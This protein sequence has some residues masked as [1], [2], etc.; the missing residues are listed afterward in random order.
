MR[1]ADAGS[2]APV[3]NDQKAPGI[4]DR[5]QVEPDRLRLPAASGV[6]ALVRARLIDRVMEEFLASGGRRA[7]ISIGSGLDTRL[8]RLR[9][10]PD[11][12]ID[13]DLPEVVAI[14]REV[15]PD[16]GASCTLAGSFLEASWLGHAAR[17]VAG[18]RVLLLAEGVLNYLPVMD[19]SA[20][21]RRAAERLGPYSLVGDVVSGLLAQLAFFVGAVRRAKAPILWGASTAARL[22]RLLPLRVTALEPYLLPDDPTLGSSRA[23]YRLPLLRRLSQ[24][25]RAE[26]RPTATT[27]F[28]AKA[29]VPA[30]WESRGGA[31][32][33]VQR[34][35]VDRRGFWDVEEDRRTGHDRRHLEG[36]G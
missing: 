26:A 29:S 6:G 8:Q 35:S 1:A 5:I 16:D 25:A 15:L 24:L 20:A 12:W 4:L 23:M 27:A 9:G 36:D 31:S 19:L 18:A 11:V 21:L 17:L 30:A 7:V 14:R 2:R 13:L 22:E 33:G 10:R 32:T 3:L 34:Q 28:G